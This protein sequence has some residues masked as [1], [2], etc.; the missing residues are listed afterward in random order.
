MSAPAATLLMVEDDDG[1]A[2]LIEKNIQRAGATGRIIRVRD[3]ASAFSTLAAR[4]GEA[5]RFVML[6]DMNLPDMS[7]VDVLARVKADPGLRRLP[8]LVLT[9]SDDRGEIQR[10]YELGCSLYV[11]KPLAYERFAEAVRQIGRLVGLMEVPD[12]ASPP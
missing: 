7:G 2:R 1:H 9:T 10:C 12:C 3:G 5:A 4:T 11:T 6:L 8:V